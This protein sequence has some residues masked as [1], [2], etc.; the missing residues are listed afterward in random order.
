M[1]H[2]LNGSR[3]PAPVPELAAQVLSRHLRRRVG[4]HETGLTSGG[5]G[6]EALGLSAGPRSA[7]A[8]RLDELCRAD[9]D[10]VRRPALNRVMYRASEVSVPPYAGERDAEGAP[11]AFV[12]ADVR[13]PAAQ[14]LYDM[15]VIFVALGERHGGAHARTSLI[16]YLAD[17]AL[18]LLDDART[19]A[20]RRRLGSGLA[21]LTQVLADAT[22]DTG[23][24]GLAQRYHRLSLDLAAA[25][26]DPSV[27]LVSLASMSVHAHL[28]GHRA[29][30]LALAEAG[31]AA[32]GPGAPPLVRA[33]LLAQR[34]HLRAR[35]GCSREAVADLSALDRY[36][37]EGESEA[38]AYGA[39]ARASVDFKRAEAFLALGDHRTAVAVLEASLRARPVDHVRAHALTH[40]L[41]AMA[42]LRAGRLEVACHHSRTFLD[43]AGSVDSHHVRSALGRLRAEFRPYHRASPSAALV[44]RLAQDVVRSPVVV[45]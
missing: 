21:W 36:R 45:A 30:G 1:A 6:W 7:P 3:P 35:T 12:V 18:P 2:W 38:G 40:A 31:L 11:S 34:G 24:H 10:P 43:T 29:H 25:G 22:M 27:R 26:D 15:T 42:H 8:V 37:A 44:E 4:A 20:A 13:L 5:D 19:E 23:S 33:F 17:S 32:A 41:L 28:L 16:S 9:L 14:S 39:F